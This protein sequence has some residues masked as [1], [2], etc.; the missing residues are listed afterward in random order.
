M[1]TSKK[2]VKLTPALLQAIIK[3]E[4]ASFGKMEDVEDTKAEEVDADEQA[5]SL[6]K[7]IDYMKAL[8]IEESRLVKRLARVREAKERAAKALVAKV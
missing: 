4:V 8:K 3:E 6:E 1:S 7:H 5:D 2:T